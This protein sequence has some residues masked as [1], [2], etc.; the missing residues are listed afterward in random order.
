MSARAPSKHIT[1]ALLCI[2]AVTGCG[3]GGDNTSTSGS[4]AASAANVATMQVDSGPSA[5]A[6][7]PNTAFVTI[8]LCTPAGLACQNIDH[9]AVDT[10]SNGL[11]LFAS[12]LTSLS[13]LPLQ[14]DAN[15]YAVAECMQFASGYAWGTIRVAQLSI[16]GEVASNL[17]VQ[18]IN[19]S[20]V[21]APTNSAC[22]SASITDGASF[23]ANGILGIGVFRQDCGSGCAP[24][25]ATTSEL[26]YSCPTSSTCQKTLLALASQ[27]QNPV[28]Q[29]STDNNGVILEMPALGAAGATSASGALVFGIGTQSNN[30]LGT[31][32][33]LA[34]DANTGYFQTSLAGQS[35]LN[36][37]F[38]SGSSALFFDDSALPLCSS[39]G[40]AA[41]YYCPAQE[42]SLSATLV[43]T[44]AASGGSLSFRV[45]NAEALLGN[46]TT[47][48][49]YN[50]LAAPNPVH[51]TYFTWG[52]PIFYGHRIV[53]AI[54]GQSTS[55]G[56]G[57]YE[58]YD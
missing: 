42:Q 52:L 31:A 9:I 43:G 28:W 29:F 17:P 37:A 4:I 14:T 40:I 58:G 44:G 7:P 25:S 15:G 5:G 33:I 26:Y 11:R 53:I 6:A 30:T 8:T 24:G 13:S 3:G 22:A 19:D 48:F 2:L 21:V 35:Y 45:A 41:G 34:T 39:S 10:G 27:V 47:F 38:D 12:E 51:S 49:A 50:D 46:N 16:A 18:I 20:T 56:V 36:S 55:A 57:P 1:P 54:E 32:T 23:G